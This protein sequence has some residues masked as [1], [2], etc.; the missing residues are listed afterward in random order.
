MEIRVAFIFFVIL[1]DI[2]TPNFNCVEYWQVILAFFIIFITGILDD[3]FSLDA[4]IKFCLQ[5]ASALIIALS[6][7]YFR[8]FWGLDLPFEIGR[9]AIFFWITNPSSS[10]VSI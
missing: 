8:H 9:F 4:K 6:P 1:Y 5:I 7:F 10:F 3:Y 2:S